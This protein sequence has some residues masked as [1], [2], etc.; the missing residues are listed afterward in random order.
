M[1]ENQHEF[2]LPVSVKLLRE[3]TSRLRRARI[4]VVAHFFI[5]GMIIAV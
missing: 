3:R 5:A 4:A 1:A 2:R